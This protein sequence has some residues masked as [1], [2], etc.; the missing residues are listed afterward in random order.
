MNDTASTRL[1]IEYVT[2]IEV[3]GIETVR[4]PAPCAH[5]LP[6]RRRYSDAH[7]LRHRDALS[8]GHG[9]VERVRHPVVCGTCESRS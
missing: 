4:L 9:V 2:S 3:S 6:N 5:Y 8:D 1:L 7:R